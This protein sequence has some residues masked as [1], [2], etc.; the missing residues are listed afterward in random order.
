[1]VISF[2]IIITITFVLMHKIPG[3][4]LTSLPKNLPDSIKT[5]Y[6]IKYGLEKPLLQQYG[7]YIKNILCGNLG[8]SLI[9][10]GRE[11]KD[12]I[13]EYSP[14]SITLG[15]QATVLGFLAG[16]ILGVFAALKKNKLS[17]RIINIIALLG[18]SIPS[19]VVAALLQYM[20]SVKYQFFPVTGYS[21][22]SYTI[23]P[24]L[25]LSIPIFAAY[26]RFVRTSSLEVLNKEYI[27]TARAK[28][29]KDSSLI[30]KHIIRN[31]I[32]PAIT[33]L[34]MQLANVLAGSFVIENIFAIPG[35][36]THFV[37]SV[38][39]RDYSVIMGLTIFYSALYMGSLLLSD[40]LYVIAD[41]RIKIN[42]RSKGRPT[43]TMAEE[44]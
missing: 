11:V 37:L 36:G 38:V 10:P 28:G 14:A 15:I 27:L 29:I 44:L 25:A 43:G 22:F 32:I 19:F 7:I 16:T 34:G 23:L 5:N 1:M 4:P 31:G 20:F 18:I 35:L 41:P 12:I 9:Y 6:Y 42:G 40:L 17:D 8:E 33:I 2:W 39:N 13:R 24:T 21:G 3:D 26:G 30:F